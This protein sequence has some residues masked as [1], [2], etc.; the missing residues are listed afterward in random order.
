MF[1]KSGNYRNKFSTSNNLDSSLDFRE[2]KLSRIAEN[3]NNNTNINLNCLKQSNLNCLKGIHLYI[4]M[5]IIQLNC[6]YSC[7]LYI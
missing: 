3:N 6:L 2:R 4:H 1:G 7:I 5:Y